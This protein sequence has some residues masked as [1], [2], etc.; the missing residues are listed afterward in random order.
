MDGI[1][2]SDSDVFLYGGKTVYKDLEEINK[3]RSIY[4]Y[5]YYMFISILRL[6]KMILLEQR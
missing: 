3:V 1:L 4:I 2:T 6:E 5:I